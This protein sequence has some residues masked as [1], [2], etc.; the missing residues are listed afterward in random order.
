ML[1]KPREPDGCDSLENQINALRWLAKKENHERCTVCE[2]NHMWSAA[3]LKNLR[4]LKGLLPAP[5][6]RRRKRT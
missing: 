4:K 1:K 2:L 6:A 3:V 5:S